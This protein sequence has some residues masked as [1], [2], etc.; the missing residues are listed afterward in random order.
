LA[1]ASDEPVA[2]LAQ[3][4]RRCSYLGGTVHNNERA[5]AFKPSP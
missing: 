4:C 5:V 1:L 2:P 3:Q